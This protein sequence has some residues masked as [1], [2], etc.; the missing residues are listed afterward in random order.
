MSSVFWNNKILLEKLAATS[1][2]KFSDAENPL[3]GYRFGMFADYPKQ[4]AGHRRNLHA[5]LFPVA[6]RGRV[7]AYPRGEP[8]LRH[9]QTAADFR[10]VKFRGT[11]GALFGYDLFGLFEGFYKLAEVFVAHPLEVGIL[12]YVLR[13]FC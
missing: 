10:R 2:R 12:R 8:F 5:T 1:A 9:A 3:L 11:P 4:G 6:Q 13:Q 7:D